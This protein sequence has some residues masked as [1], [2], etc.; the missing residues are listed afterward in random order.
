MFPRET[1]DF[2]SGLQ[3]DAGAEAVW[4]GG[5]RGEDGAWRQVGDSL[6][7]PDAVTSVTS[8]SRTLTSSYLVAAG[9][10][11]GAIHVL[12]WSLESSW[13]TLMVIDK[14]T[15][16]HH[17]TVTRLQFRPNT[18]DF[19]LASCSTDTSVRILKLKI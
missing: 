14:N 7:L 3:E 8:A 1:D 17:A 12:T 18:E 10:E 19:V 16:G 2:L 15:K 5:S 11:N 13:S 9:L 4:V 6:N